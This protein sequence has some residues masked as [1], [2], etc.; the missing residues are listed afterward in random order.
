M[1][2]NKSIRHLVAAAEDRMRYHWIDR[3]RGFESRRQPCRYLVERRF[4]GG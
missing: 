4:L 1:H 2:R 3:D